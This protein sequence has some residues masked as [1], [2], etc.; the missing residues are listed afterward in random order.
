MHGLK[1]AIVTACRMLVLLKLDSG[2]FGNVSIRVPGTETY[3]VNPEGKIFTEVTVDDL[4]LMNLNGDVLD[5]QHQPH[6]GE[7]I[8]REIYRRRQDVNAIV[9]THSEST[10]MHSLLGQTIEAHTQLG[11]S[12]YGDQGLYQG[13]SG[14]VR[15]SHEGA[16]IAE[17][18]GDK[19]IVIAKNHGLFTASSSIRAAWWDMVIADAAAKIHVSAKQ[20]GLPPAAIPSAAILEKS[21]REVRVRQCE[22][23]WHS[24]AAN[25]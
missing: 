5:G 24:Y 8:H 25:L 13:F 4:V 2:P 21:R 9:H 23:M 15:D 6:P 14:P 22:A 11:A 10:V 16:A 7:F 18:L 19:A 17:A 12:L 1:Q 3:W 20:L